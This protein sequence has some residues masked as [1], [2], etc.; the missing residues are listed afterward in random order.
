MNLE[1]TLAHGTIDHFFLTE[2]PEELSPVFI[3]N[4]GLSNT[5][6]TQLIGELPHI[7][8]SQLPNFL[9]DKFNSLNDYWNLLTLDILSNLDVTAIINR[10]D[11]QSLIVLLTMAGREVA[12]AFSSFKTTLDALTTSQLPRLRLLAHEINNRPA[13]SRQELKQL[14]QQLALPLDD[15]D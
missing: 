12:E 1:Q 4:T 2:S 8:S 13:N 11:C 15:F 5:E 3:S 7:S 6:F 9:A 14:F 10:L